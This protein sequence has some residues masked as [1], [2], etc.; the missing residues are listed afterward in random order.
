MPA[1]PPTAREAEGA[2]DRTLLT[3]I[4][5]EVLIEL[6][7][8]ARIFS[9]LLTC[10]LLYEHLPRRQGPIV[11]NTR[12]FARKFST[13]N[14]F[15]LSKKDDSFVSVNDVVAGLLRFRDC[16]LRLHLENSYI[17]RFPFPFVPPPLQR[18]L[19]R[20]CGLGKRGL[21]RVQPPPV[22]VRQ[23]AAGWLLRAKGELRSLHVRYGACL[24]A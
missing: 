8:C 3:L 15:L 7:P 20:C 2:K 6:W 5:P 23:R 16:D 4:P 12:M 1:A 9:G 24:R 11:V 17:V 14:F 19:K 13:V 21:P 10:K 18:V 22:D